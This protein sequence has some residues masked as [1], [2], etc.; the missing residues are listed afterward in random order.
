M[1]LK[2]YFQNRDCLRHGPPRIGDP[3]QIAWTDGLIYNGTF[4]GTNSQAMYTVRTGWI[5]PY[6]S[7]THCIFDDFAEI[8]LRIVSMS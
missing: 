2:L 5:L 1:I 6:F 7:Q 8:V 3:I 4:Q